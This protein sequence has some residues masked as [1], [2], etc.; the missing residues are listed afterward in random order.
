MSF[1][2]SFNVDFL[3]QNSTR[4]HNA[5]YDQN[6]FLST[7]NESCHIKVQLYPIWY[8]HIAVQWSV[9]ADWGSC[10]FN[11]YYSPSGTDDWQR[12]NQSLLTG[13]Y[14]LDPEEQ[15]YSK[16]NK[17]FYIVE[18]VLLDKGNVS[19]KSDSYSYNT[20]QRNWVTLRSTEIQRREY[21]LLS[22]F[23]GIKTYLFKRK[24]FGERCP[25][26]WNYSTEQSFK[27]HCKTCLGTSFKGGYFTGAPCFVQYDQS[28]NSN[29]KSYF[30]VWEAN[31]IGAWTISWPPIHPD[32]IILRVGDWNIYHV[33]Q[34]IPTELQGNP[35]RQM[36][37][38]SQ[39]DKDEIQN[40]LV[41]KNL[42]D[43][44]SLYT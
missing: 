4:N 40:Q 39:L 15:E 28:P 24:T 6:S 36:L 41:T 19:I 38:L 21:L 31:K 32:D 29:I 35:V 30:G 5:Q 25:E 17:G 1:N 34:V 8:K 42:A 7:T 18:A 44:P 16:F 26:C 20:Y 13:P 43:F 10:M 9:P 33:D 27:D 11:V 12:M 23:V 14:F 3:L 37:K 22:K 2:F